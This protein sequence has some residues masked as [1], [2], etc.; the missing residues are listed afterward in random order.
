MTTGANH[1]FPPVLSTPAIHYLQLPLTHMPASQT[2]PQ[3][4]QF[5]LSTLVL[6]HVPWPASTTPHIPK[7]AGQPHIEFVQTCPRLQ[8]FPHPPQ[9]AGLFVM[10]V[11][12]GGVP[13]RLVLVGHTQTPPVQTLPPVQAIPQPPQL[14]G[15]SFVST[16]AP[17]Q[18]VVPFGQVVV[19]VIEH[20]CVELHIVPQPPQFCGSV[21]VSTQTPPHS[22]PGAQPHVPP[23]Q[24]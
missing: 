20:T 6:V 4:P 15:S 12:T 7:P 22:V 5:V 21:V 18:F 8:V 17:V 13:Q 19:Q 3:V 1:S 23:L 10:L 24:T 16:Q 2:L 11:Q 9:L 14:F